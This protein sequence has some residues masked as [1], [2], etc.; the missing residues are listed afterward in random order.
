LIIGQTKLYNGVVYDKKHI[1]VNRP[2]DAFCTSGGF[3]LTELL[4]LST[5]VYT[6][7][8][9]RAAES[10]TITWQSASGQFTQV[11]WGSFDPDD[12]RIYPSD[13]CFLVSGTAP[14]QYLEDETFNIMSGPF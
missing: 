4:T 14:D 8:F 3:D 9:S 2:K 5:T 10:Q 6:D 12:V 13:T 7:T 1:F 11:V